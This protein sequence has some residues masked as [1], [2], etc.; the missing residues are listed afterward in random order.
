M[1]HSK[2]WNCAIATWRGPGL[3]ELAA[4]KK[5]KSLSLVR[6]P[7]TDDGCQS[8]VGLTTL[9][10]LNVSETKIT[11]RALAPLSRIANLRTLNLSGTAVTLD[12]LATLAA[13]K[14]LKTVKV[15]GLK[16]SGEDLAN[17]RKKTPRRRRRCGRPRLDDLRARADEQ[18]R[19]RGRAGG[20]AAVAQQLQSLRP[21]A[22]RGKGEKASP[23]RATAIGASNKADGIV[24]HSEAGNAPQDKGSPSGPASKTPDAGQ[25]SAGGSTRGSVRLTFTPDNSVKGAVQ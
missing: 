20:R 11:D 2:A 7:I 19:R 24:I 8:L 4:L 21:H 6:A 14:E 10:D 9:Q 16:T 25:P 13:A 18:K 17:L 3:A 1:R 15:E 23:A 22:G 5:L 12:G